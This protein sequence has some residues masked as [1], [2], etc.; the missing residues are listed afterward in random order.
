MKRFLALLLTASL[1]LTLCSCFAQRYIESEKKPA[2]K[3]EEF[4]VENP[5]TFEYST[6]NEHWKEGNA[7]SLIELD[8]K[9]S[10]LLPGDEITV[11]VKVSSSI[12]SE[13]AF[14]F[15]IISCN[16]VLGPDQQYFLSERIECAYDKNLDDP[17]EA[18]GKRS[19]KKGATVTGNVTGSAPRT[20]TIKLSVPADVT[21]SEIVGG[22]FSISAKVARP[23]NKL[24]AELYY[25][26]SD[27]VGEW[28]EVSAFTSVFKPLTV[29]EPG[30]VEIA[31]LKVS[32]AGTEDFDYNLT[33]DITDETEGKNLNGKSFKLSDYIYLGAVDGDVELDRISAVD[34][35]QDN[36]KPISK[37][38]IKID[39]IKASG[40]DQIVTLVLYMPASVGN[41]ANC[42]N[43]SDAP[44]LRLSVN[45]IAK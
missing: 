20:F 35:V 43:E 21:K 2:A 4:Y 3:P 8:R 25:Y 10:E 23:I 12:A 13:A 29:V 15:E 32:N 40:N 31:K 30:Y 39:S 14:A 36:A 27:A 22:S 37:G 41:E 18:S 19:L 38:F 11:Y 6:D 9:T 45:L 5:F 1:L 42:A 44:E 34:A 17:T 24:D 16:D 26:D 33:V 7:E 28:A